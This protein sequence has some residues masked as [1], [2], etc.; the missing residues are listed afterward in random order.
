MRVLKL[1]CE[2]FQENFAAHRRGTRF[3]QDFEEIEK[4]EGSDWRLNKISAR[5]HV[6][7]TRSSPG[8]H[9]IV[10]YVPNVGVF[11]SKRLVPLI[12]Q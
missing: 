4:N 1:Q 7:N 8:V 11:P 3:I 6:K 2:C 9:S 12:A 10:M 5:G